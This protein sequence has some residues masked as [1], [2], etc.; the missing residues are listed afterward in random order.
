M[1]S[2]QKRKL[3]VVGLS[4][5]RWFNVKTYFNWGSL[6]ET[7]HDL[8]CRVFVSNRWHLQTQSKMRFG[9]KRQKFARRISL[10]ARLL[11]TVPR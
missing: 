11:D 8:S 9:A 10:A 5:Q 6:V 3:E 2:R 7:R 4:R 1:P